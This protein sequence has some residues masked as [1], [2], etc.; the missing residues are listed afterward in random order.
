MTDK[1]KVHVISFYFC[2]RFELSFIRVPVTDTNILPHTF[3]HFSSDFMMLPK[4]KEPQYRG[5]YSN[6]LCN[7][8]AVFRFL[9]GTRE[10]SL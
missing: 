3:K 9:V 7:Q 6:W 2:R 4:Q 10:L 5:R 8:G 1:R